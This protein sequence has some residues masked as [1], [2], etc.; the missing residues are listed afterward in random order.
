MLAAAKLELA[1]R[2]SSHDGDGGVLT[3]SWKKYCSTCTGMVG[4]DGPPLKLMTRGT[5]EGKV[6]N[7]SVSGKLLAR[8]VVIQTVKT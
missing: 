1:V 2:N 3:R 6:E 8:G 7:V 5:C 4:M